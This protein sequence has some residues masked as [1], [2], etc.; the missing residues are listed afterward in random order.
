MV[1]LF[2]WLFYWLAT[3]TRTSTLLGPLSPL[4][5]LLGL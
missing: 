2:Y 4:A 3:A 5:G 1:W